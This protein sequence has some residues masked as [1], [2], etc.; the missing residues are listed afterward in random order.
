[1]DRAQFLT[2]A[3]QLYDAF[4]AGGGASAGAGPSAAPSHSGGAGAPK[5]DTSIIRKGGMVQYASETDLSGLMF[6]KG[7]ADEPP[8]DPKYAESNA[9][10]SK[11]LSYWVA[12]RQAEPIAVWS[13]ERNRVNVTAAAPSAMPAT[14]PRPANGGVPVAPATPTPTFEEDDEIPF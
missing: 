10:Q 9:K 6:W 8:S 11:S 2:L 4:V 3:G 5:F 12:Y 14:Y 1:M 13:G 7:R